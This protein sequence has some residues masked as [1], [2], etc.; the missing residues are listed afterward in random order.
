MDIVFAVA[1]GVFL[2]A[3]LPL[4]RSGHARRG[5][6][7]GAASTAFIATAFASGAWDSSYGRW[8]LLAL[9]FGWVG[10]VALVSAQRSWF[11]IGLVAFLVSHLLY[12]VAFMVL[13]LDA[14]PGLIAAAALIV[15]A[16]VV[17]RWLWARLPDEMRAPVIAYIV[18]ISAM[19]AA[20]VGTL[21]DGAPEIVVVAAA[22]FYVSDI[23]VARDRFA[24][25]AFANRVLGLPLYYAAQVLFALS[26]GL[27]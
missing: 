13:G 6:V 16:A 19:V 20:S 15:P 27:V 4:E 5:W 24:A 12:I 11:L 8:V 21:A 14:A 26:T 3:L 2:A 17:L 18:V 1:T 23:F 10:D 9:A 7:K 22:L 25:P